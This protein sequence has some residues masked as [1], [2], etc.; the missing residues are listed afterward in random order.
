MGVH[1]VKGFFEKINKIIFFIKEKCL[2]RCLSIKYSKQKKVLLLLS[3]I[4]II[5]ASGISTVAFYKKKLRTE[6][7]AA[8]AR[9]KYLDDI[10]ITTKMVEM[11]DEIEE[12]KDTEEN[13]FKFPDEEKR[14]YAVMIDNEGTKC[15]PQGGL[16]KAQIIYEIVVEGGETRLMSIFWDVEPE[17]I[18]P[19]RSSRHYFL[20]YVLEYDAIYVHFGWSPMALYDIPKLK[21]NNIN[22]VANGGEIFWDLTD[23]I[24]NW[25]DS[26]TSM[27]KI[28]EYVNRVNYRR[29]TEKPQV[30]RYNEKDISF[31]G[32]INAEKIK[33]KYNQL[34][35]SE[36]EFDETI[37]E[38]YRKRKGNPHMERVSEGQLKA[39]NIVIQ[40][41]KNY[42]IPG[43]KED[44]QEVVT[45][46]EGD[47]WFITCGKAI[48]IKWSKKSRDEATKY[49][50][51]YGNDVMLNPGQTW[52]QIVPL[53][54]TVEIG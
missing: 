27:E 19:V 7:E 29:E 53:Y 28:E 20:D 14:P 47:G 15:L 34:N 37:G 49:T 22:G 10:Q 51:K 13:R 4:L 18:G 12:T 46:S 39:K 41:A 3:I 48:E 31:R 23:D 24:Y 36:Y 21:I 8:L 40:F 42:T 16:D 26:Y 5:I 35:F 43:D 50:D 54:G 45:V 38:Y 17:L 11:V 44:R 32:G 30:F 25:Q 33:I 52:I 9:Q 1:I 6:K 2:T